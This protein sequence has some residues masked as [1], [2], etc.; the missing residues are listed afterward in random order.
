MLDI[1]SH[2]GTYGL[3][4][5]YYSK[6]VHCFEP[7]KMTYYALCGGVSLSDVRNINCINVALG[8]EEQIRTCENG[9]ITL[10]IRSKDG[11][12]SSLKDL[13]DK[14]L[15]T[16][17]VDIRTLDS[18]NINNVGFIK[19]DVEGNELEVIKGGKETI[20]A[21]NNPVILFES[22]DH[23]EVLF[24]YLMSEFGY[25]IIKVTGI[26]NMYLACII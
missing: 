18:F 26:S 9:K 11:G 24:N 17:M 1:G 7:Q 22:N 20:K 6:E 2:T 16:E 8:S 15:T 12:G 25:K 5:S 13:G 19:I 10:K 4:L 3:S 21:N 23:D 14:I